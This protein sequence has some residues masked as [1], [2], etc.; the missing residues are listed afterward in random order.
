[1]TIGEFAEL[2]TAFC[3]TGALVISAINTFKIN[4]VHKLTNSMKDQL[5]AT[6]GS[7]EHAKGVIVGRAEVLSEEGAAALF[8]GGMGYGGYG[9]GHYWGTGYYGGG[10]GLIVVIVLVIFLLRGGL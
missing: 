6:T 1:M 5:V 8:G 4:A 3:A 10:L 9:P 7:A 2:T